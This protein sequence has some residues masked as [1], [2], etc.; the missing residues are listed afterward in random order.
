[1][2]SAPEATPA[3]FSNSR[4]LILM[5]TLPWRKEMVEIRTLSAAPVGWKLGGSWRINH[6]AKQAIRWKPEVRARE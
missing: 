2:S 1:M 5:T 4:R 6:S 3:F